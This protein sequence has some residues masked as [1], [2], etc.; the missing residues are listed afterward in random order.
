MK[1][2]RRA[3]VAPVV[4]TAMMA[5]TAHAQSSVTLYGVVDEGLEYVSNVKTGAG[6]KS[7]FQ[8]D[9]VSGLQG[10]RWGL[11]GA[12]DLGG[13]L[14]AIFTLENG[15]DLNSG[16]LGQGGALFGRQAYVGLS[17]NS[18][19]AVT[20]GRQ[21]DSV[22]DYVE[23]YVAAAQWASHRAAHPGDLDNL[24]NS[25]RTDNAV[26]YASPNFGG[27]TFGGLYSFGG[28]PGSMSRNQV[29]SL[30]ASYSGGPVS[31]GVG[32]L[33]VR[34]P[35][36]SYFGDNPNGGGV[37]TNNV[38]AATNPVFSGY[39]SAR[40]YE[41]IAAGGAYTFGSATL[42]VTYSNIRFSNLGDTAASGPNPLHYTGN[43][44]FNNFEVNAKY[45]ITPSLVAGFAYDYTKG[46]AV[47]STDPSVHNTGVTYHQFAL[48]TDYNLSKRTDVYL[49]GIYQKASGVDSTGNEA[50]ASL[51]N[52]TAAAGNHAALIRGGLRVKF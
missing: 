36:V 10:S 4:L 32:Y 50:V 34:N 7:L 46:N 20:L 15:F 52:V 35:N 23:A 45:Q 17:S 39:S 27:F 21:Y 1:N 37:T 38:S 18:F 28:Q 51:P 9:S 29:Y 11:R 30:G 22:V 43:A 3:V 14:K 40:T 44:T 25:V 2:S 33:N 42:G 41:V 48:G 49:L 13:G 26:K 6:G 47:T 31:L 12:E 24:N 5:G 16:K 19:G 8:L